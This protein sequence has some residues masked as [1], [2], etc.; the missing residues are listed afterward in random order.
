MTSPFRPDELIVMKHFDKKERRTIERTVVL[1]SGRLRVAREQLPEL[2]LDSSLLERS[3][4]YAVVRVSARWKGGASCGLG[5]S[6]TSSEKE[7][8]QRWAVC[9]AE[10]RARH[11]CLSAAGIGTEFYGAEE[12]PS[13]E[14][15]VEPPARPAAP[16]P[17]TEA[18]STAA[19]WRKAVADRMT[20]MFG[21]V[22]S[23][24]AAL[25]I[26]TG[27]KATATLNDRDRDK[28]NVALDLISQNGNDIDATRNIVRDYFRLP[29]F[30]D[31]SDAD[32]T[33]IR[34]NISGQPR[35]EPKTA[36]STPPF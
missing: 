2:E 18:P 19:P 24:K 34:N 35:P 11:R 28:I 9:L 1:I 21:S 22:D 32:F 14:D 29:W 27:H 5:V 36:G 4:D 3:N 15:D 17:A 26:I 10:T 23:A 20:K 8:M 6:I 30:T 31:M 33:V 12:I 13:D 7:H 25:Q 16:P